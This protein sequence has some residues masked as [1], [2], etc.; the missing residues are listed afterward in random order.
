VQFSENMYLFENCGINT[1][2]IGEVGQVN[3]CCL[4]GII[5]IHTVERWEHDRTLSHPC[6]HFCRCVHYAVYRYCEFSLGWKGA[7]TLE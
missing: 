1:S 7:N 2:N 6:L 4:G 5:Y 3:T